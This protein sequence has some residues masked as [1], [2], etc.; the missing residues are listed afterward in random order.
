M[1]GFVSFLTRLEQWIFRNPKLILGFVA[2]LTLFFASR[3]P[4]VKMYSD[5]SDLLPQKHEYIELH[6]EIRDSFGGAN[7]VIM[8][9]E[10][11]EGTIFTSET[12]SLIHELTQKVDSLP[13]INH[14][15]VTSLTHRT[16][17]KVYL[18]EQ[19]DINSEPYYDPISREL[20]GPQLEKLK[21]D[22]LANPRV[23]GLLVSPDMKAALIKGPLNEGALDYPKIFEEV[24]SA[25]AMAD[26][27]EGVSIHAAGQPVLVG[28]V[29]SYIGQ[30]M[31][32]FLLTALIMLALLIGCFRRFYGVLVPLIGIVVSAIWGL[33]II[34]LLGFNLDPL[35]LV[36]PFLISARALSHGIQL[37]QRY[38]YELEEVQDGR[39][40]AKR[41]FESLFR[42]GSLGV[43]SDAIG[44]FLISLGSIPINTKLA[45][46]A[47]I[48][49]FS[50]ILTVLISVPLILSILPTPKPKNRSVDGEVRVGAG[51]KI[52][53]NTGAFLAKRNVSKNILV[54]GAVVLL[55]GLG[56]ASRVQIGEAEPGSPLLYPDHDYNLSAKSIN[57]SFP[58]SEEL[59]VVA[60]TAEIGGM[61]NPEVLAAIDS[62]KR[63]M[64]NDPELGG[65]KALPDLVKQ[66]NQLIHS[67]D[68]RWQQIPND[69]SYI[70]GLLF[71][72]MASSPIPGATDEFMTSD[73][74]EANI[75]FYYKDHRGETI[76][77]AIHL[78]KTWINDPENQV[79]GLSF[80]LA[81]GI[82]GVTAAGN[83]AAFETN[84]LVLPLVLLLI[85]VFVT[86]FYWSFQA[87]WMMFMAMFFATTLSYAY[88]GLAGVGININTV[89]VI[90]IGVGV[91]ID[92]S[93][94]IMDRIREE[95]GK[96]AGSIEIA[97][98]RAQR[99]TGVAIAFTAITLMCGVIMWKFVSSL[100]FQ[101]D[102]A[103][104]LCVM[105]FLNA[106][107]ALIIVPSWIRIFKPKFITNL[108]VFEEHAVV[109]KT[110][111]V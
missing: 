52:L 103:M 96:G 110:V 27:V 47:S 111:T 62:L 58:G 25:R 98:R 82:I 95:M 23:Y 68:P 81:G 20:T 86:L 93:I 9:V 88:M 32:I 69:S 72:Y 51:Q 16:S 59:F 33:G 60:R 54:M 55:I 46:Y 44:I 41:T 87:G 80:H 74:N 90:A 71:T 43:V 2:L 24:Q 76:R 30:V 29:H 79:E 57:Q 75:V 66:V 37:V 107:A 45:Y 3:V 8:S 63:H 10:V 6:N 89:P 48:W 38:Y 4:Y 78:L 18:T 105:L 108:K 100:R 102:A 13:S 1:Q 19:G 85:F 34:S 104:L 42:P 73:E 106:T 17:R 35:I 94:Y 70:G 61:K 36:I 64:L 39:E 31:K 83:E 28:W 49:A 101:A 21:N 109:E 26:N 67:D 56:L 77:R 22:V 84:L 11:D 50:V 53:T 5:F 92:Y 97:V 12:L 40:A 99:T 7:I 91:G 15:L 14:N 65:V